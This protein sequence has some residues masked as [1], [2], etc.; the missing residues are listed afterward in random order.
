MSRL[1]SV[2]GLQSVIGV[3]PIV[4][5][6]MFFIGFFAEKGRK[7]SLVRSLKIYENNQD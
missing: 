5:F 1:F 6:A 2:L 4:F 7:D 3:L